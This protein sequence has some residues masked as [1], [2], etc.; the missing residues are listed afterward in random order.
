MITEN[1]SAEVKQQV[2]A[3]YAEKNGNGYK[4]STEAIARQFN[5]N[6]SSL[7]SKIARKEGVEPRRALRPFRRSVQSVPNLPEKVV[8]E[9]LEAFSA[10]DTANRYTYSVREIA[11]LAGL[12]GNGAPVVVS[13]I[14]NAHGLRRRLFTR[15][16]PHQLYEKIVVPPKVSAELHFN[17]DKIKAVHPGRIWRFTLLEGHLVIVWNN[18]YEV[19]SAQ[20]FLTAS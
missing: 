6:N 1:L 4:H 5:L 12:E 16:K 15:R 7:V 13:K 10:R 17:E 18:P 9:I 19:R 20:L 3:M 14:A 8:N 11:Q 2:A